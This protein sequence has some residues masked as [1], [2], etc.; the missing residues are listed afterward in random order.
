MYNDSFCKT[1][2]VITFYKKL[3][4]N[5]FEKLGFIEIYFLFIC[6]SL[7]GLLNTALKRF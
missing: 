7:T 3:R 1:N 6:H 4:K 2:E 5:T